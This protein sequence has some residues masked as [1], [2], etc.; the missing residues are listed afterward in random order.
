MISNKT[1][2]LENVVNNFNWNE[3]LCYL[4]KEHTNSTNFNCDGNQM[5]S[6]KFFKDFEILHLQTLLRIQNFT[7]RTKIEKMKRLVI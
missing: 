1:G 7:P 2:D 4:G 6:V 5:S 3:I